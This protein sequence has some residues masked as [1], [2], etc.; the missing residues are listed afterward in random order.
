MLESAINSPVNQQHYANE[1]DPARLAAALS[2]RLIN[3]HRF[4]NGNKRTALLAAN[5]FLLQN[6]KVLQQDALRVENND[7]IT[8][9]HHKVAM[10]KMEEPELAEFY[11]QR[12]GLPQMPTTP[13]PRPY[14]RDEAFSFA[15]NPPETATQGIRTSGGGNVLSCLWKSF[16]PDILS[17]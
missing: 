11:R 9:A 15:H 3:N 17:D 6:G 4:A 16:G 8:R 2:S 13:R 5:L 1:N 14:M 7:A 10:G 12:G